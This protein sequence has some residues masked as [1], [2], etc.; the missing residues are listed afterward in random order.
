[1]V[2]IN[3]F[4]PILELIGRDLDS[5]QFMEFKRTKSA[6]EFCRANKTDKL[7]WALSECYDTE[8]DA[9]PPYKK[10][11]FLLKKILLDNNILPG[12]RISTTRLV[13]NN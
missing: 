5:E 10:V 7:R 9:D 4:D 11:D 13:Q 2:L 8:Y 12:G 6:E 3:G 1:M